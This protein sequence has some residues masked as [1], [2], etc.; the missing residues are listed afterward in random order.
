M[1]GWSTREAVCTSYPPER[2]SAVIPTVMPS[3]ADFSLDGRARV[4]VFD[5]GIVGF[6]RTA[7]LPLPAGEGVSEVHAH[8]SFRPDGVELVAD[9]GQLHVRGADGG[10]Q[11]TAEVVLAPGMEVRIGRFVLRCAGVGFQPSARLQGRDGSALDRMLPCRIG[12][13]PGWATWLIQA[14]ELSP[15]H[16]EIDVVC[17]ENGAHSAVIRAVDGD[18]VDRKST[19]LNSSHSSVSR[20]PSSA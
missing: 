1:T 2:A 17:D 3:Y 12:S 5:G 13:A 20:M 18:V 19:R 4:R 6:A 8:V 10:W 7:A 11:D 16:A 15:K 9:R 14:P